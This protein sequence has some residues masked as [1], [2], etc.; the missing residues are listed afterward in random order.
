ML[1]KAIITLI[2]LALTFSM[3]SIF[4]GSGLTSI[5]SQTVKNDIPTFFSFITIVFIMAMILL[6]LIDFIIFIKK[7]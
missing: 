1:R 2:I 5:T 7:K 6:V 3:L 4:T